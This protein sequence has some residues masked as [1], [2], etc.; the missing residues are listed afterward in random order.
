[1]TGRAASETV[2]AFDC[3]EKRVG[4]AVGNDFLRTASALET[5]AVTSGDALFARIA[6]LIDEWQPQRLVVG[7]PYADGGDENGTP[8]SAARARSTAPRS[9]RSRCERFANRLHG[10]FG[11]P[12][13][14]IDERYTSIDA[15]SLRRE[16]RSEG[17]SRR[18][19]GND[20]LAAQCI[21]Q[22]YF[23][24]APKGPIGGASAAG[25]VPVSRNHAG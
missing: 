18:T 12:V 16:L 14:R 1:V 22:R 10:R 13:E 6:A 2:L 7:I 19:P 11:L 4:V 3:G 20:H 8:R 9:Q 24:E 15:D 25:E 5:I 21:L 23:D 17:L